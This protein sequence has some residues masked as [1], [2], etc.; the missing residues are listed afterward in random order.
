MTRARGSQLPDPANR[1][2]AFHHRHAQV[3]QRH[4]RVMALVG[5]DRLDAVA[6]F[7]DHA[8]IGFLVDD[9]RD[10]GS[11]QR[12]IVHEEHAGLGRRNRPT[13]SACNMDL[14]G[15]GQTAPRPARLRSRSA[16]R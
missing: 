2:D 7:G 9:V 16:A 11:E 8:Q 15:H 12:V 13:A 10:A 5:L 14:R 4:I 3:E 1:L 6:G